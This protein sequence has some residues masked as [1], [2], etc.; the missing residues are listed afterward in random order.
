MWGSWPATKTGEG[1]YRELAAWRVQS[2]EHATYPDVS[3][4]K[5]TVTERPLIYATTK[6]RFDLLAGNAPAGAGEGEGCRI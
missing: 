5:A 2:N 6:D 4:R 1:G 3:L